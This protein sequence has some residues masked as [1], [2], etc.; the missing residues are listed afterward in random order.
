M[1]S[2]TE[3]KHLLD[4]HQSFNRPNLQ[5]AQQTLEKKKIKRTNQ[6]TLADMPNYEDSED[7]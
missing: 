1:N 2:I 5:V 3:L 7:T 6:Q 4:A